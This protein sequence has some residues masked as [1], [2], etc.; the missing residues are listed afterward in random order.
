MTYD[1]KPAI[2]VIPPISVSAA[3]AAAA[4]PTT[5]AVPAAEALPAANIVVLPRASPR[6]TPKQHVQQVSAPATE[7]VQA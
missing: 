6:K 7:A 5:A 4:A 3:A 1:Q 2:T